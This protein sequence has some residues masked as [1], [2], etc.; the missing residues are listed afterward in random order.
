MWKSCFKLDTPRLQTRHFKSIYV[1]NHIRIDKH[2]SLFIWGFFNFF[3]KSTNNSISDT[4]QMQRCKEHKLLHLWGLYWIMYI[5][6]CFAALRCLL[7]NEIYWFVAFHKLVMQIIYEIN[8][9]LWQLYCFLFER[10]YFVYIMLVTIHI[11]YFYEN[12]IGFSLL[13]FDRIFYK[14]MWGFFAF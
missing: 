4:K 6:N 9:F 5:M 11:M 2:I 8:W 7:T 10:S 14:N 3:L 12:L 13:F 1:S